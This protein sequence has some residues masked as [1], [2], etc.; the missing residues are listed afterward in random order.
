VR[1][2]TEASALN[3]L[4]LW[5]GRGLPGIEV[6][7]PTIGGSDGVGIVDTVGAGVDAAWVGKRVILTAA[8][9]NMWKCSF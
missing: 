1:V 8:I 2:R 6:Q 4:D 9:M 7:W 3:H 5:V